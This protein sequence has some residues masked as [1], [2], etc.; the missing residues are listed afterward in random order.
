MMVYLTH[1]TILH[2][3]NS[4][5]QVLDV[6]N[7]LPDLFFGLAKI[8]RRYCRFEAWTRYVP[9]DEGSFLKSLES[10]VSPLQE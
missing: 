8:S 9:A 5:K 6:V 7:R 10:D 3:E 1:V 2:I 4:V